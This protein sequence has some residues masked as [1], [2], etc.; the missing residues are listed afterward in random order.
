M[1][2]YMEIEGDAERDIEQ[3][4]KMI[5]VT[6]QLPPDNVKEESMTW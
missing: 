3:Q 1:Q 4:N 2:Q 5:Q 6:M